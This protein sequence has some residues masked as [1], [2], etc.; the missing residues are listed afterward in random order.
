MKTFSGPVDVS[1]RQLH[2]SYDHGYLVGADYYW[3]GWI[4]KTDIN[5]DLL[6]DIKFGSET[7]WWMEGFD[8]TLDGGIIATGATDTLDPNWWDPYIIKMNY[9]GQVE[10]CHIFH[11]ENDL[12][13]GV[14]IL[15]LPNDSYIFLLQNWGYSQTEESIWLMH[16]DGSGEI[17]WEQRYFQDDTLV[18]PWYGNALYL[19]P[20]DN[21]LITSTCYSPIEGQTQPYWLW[22][23]LI[24]ADSTGE[25]I[26]EIP[27][28][29]TL[30]FSEH[31][32]GEGY[33]SVQINNSIYSCI[34][35]YHGINPNYA[36]CLI[37]T[38]ISGVPE[39]YKDLIEDTEYGKAS[40]LTR[41]NDSTLF[42]GAW[43]DTGYYANPTLSVLKTD[44]MGDVLVEKILNHSEYIPKDAI[45]TYD[46]KYL[47]TAPDYVNNHYIFYLWK[48]NE[49][50]EYD[51]IYT[52]PRRYD[53]LCPDTI[54]SG[55]LLF[56]CDVVTGI[57]EPV[58][59]TGKVRMHIYPNPA[60]DILHVEMPECIQKE[61]KTEHFTVI[62]VFHQWHKD[63][64]LQVFD[65]LGRL[66]YQ[67]TVKPGEKEVILDVSTWN[68][69]MYYFRLI[70]G[71]AMVASE[72]VIVD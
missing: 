2:E 50:L 72:K 28:G 41:L 51:S 18:S 57:Q 6:W 46:N 58:I 56:Q 61:S 4:I 53:S 30:P 69:G 68:P 38:S 10:W 31:V 16:L 24:L 49:N 21:Y 33:Q 52:Q 27:W 29:Y 45:L 54:T 17:L 7:I 15:S 20:D 22:P 36:P 1:P 9:C 13:Y 67:Q 70:Y 3:Q 63:L 37:K 40:T 47:I 11:T 39:Y 55:T 42:I 59:N 65:L 34:S 19:T 25:A 48:L 71:D 14:K 66:V 23:V 44:T 43:Y 60:S 35:N 12:D 26:F 32:G 8:N 5:G 64:Y 62:T